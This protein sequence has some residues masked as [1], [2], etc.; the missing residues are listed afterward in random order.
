[1]N[2][3]FRVGHRSTF[4][5]Q[6]II[7]RR[8]DIGVK[9][10]GL[11]VIIC[12]VWIFGAASL[13]AP[14][15]GAEEP[16]L[17]YYYRGEPRALKV[18]PDRVALRMKVPGGE[19]DN[20]LAVASARVAY[21]ADNVVAG[22]LPGWAVLDA[23]ALM[24]EQSL[25]KQKTG[26]S[27]VEALIDSVLK[28]GDPN[29]D[30]VSPVFL[31]DRGGTIL[32]TDR[33]LI[34]FNPDTPKHKRE[35]LRA[36]VLEGIS[37]EKVK[38]PQPN[39]ERWIVTARSGLTVLT[40]ANAL[41]RTPGVA[42]AE[43][44]MIV[45]GYTQFVPNDPGF[46]ESWGLRNT[47]QS[48]GQSGFDLAA[49]TAWDITIGS[50]S[51]IVLVMDSGVQQNHPDINQVTGRDFT[52]DAASNPNGG[53]VGIY[54]NHGTAVA[55][56]ISERI[57][58]S[59]GTT[60]IAPGAKVA[61]ARIGTNYQPNGQFMASL[62]WFADALYWGQSIGARVSNN[63]NSWS[64]PSSAVESAYRS[65]R[66]AGMVH[67]ASA[68]NNGT[69]EIA[70]PSSIP[71]VNSVAAANR[72]GQ[73]AY[74]SQF[75][76]GLAFTAP[77][78]DIL[79]TDR[80]GSLGYNNS[81]DYISISGTSFAS[82][83]AAGVAALVISRNPTWEAVQVEDSLKSTS[84]DIGATGYDTDYGYGLLNASH[85]VKG[86]ASQPNLTPYQPQGWS[87][88][89]LVS[90]VTGTHTDNSR[91]T[92]NDTLYVDFAVKNIGSMSA[93]QAFDIRIYVDNT[94]KEV[95]SV[96]SPFSPGE[97][98]NFSDYSLGRLPAGTHTIH[99]HV[100]S[101]N[102][103]E[104]SDEEDNIYTKVIRVELDPVI[105]V[106]IQTGAPLVRLLNAKS[107]EM[108]FRRFAYPKSFR[109]GVRV[110]LGDA[111]GDG[112]PDLIT[113]PGPGR[114]PRVMVFNGR[115]G[116]RLPGHI[117]SFLA[118]ARSFRGGVNVASGDVNGDGYP[119]LITGTGPGRGPRIKV[120]SGRN[121]A[122]LPG[123]IGSFL[124]YSPNFRGGVNIASGDVNGDGYDDVI[125]G[126][127]RGGIPHVKVF[128]GR[129]GARLPGRIG[130]FFAYARNF[131]GGVNVAS[132]DVNNDGVDDVITGAGPGGIPHVRVFSGRTGAQLA[133]P[134]GSF[135]A[136]GSQFSGGVNVASGDVDGDGFGDI[137]TGPG[138]GAK[139]HVRVFSG[140]TG[141]QLSRPMGSFFA[142]S[143]KFRGG[144]RVASD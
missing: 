31:D 87:D 30:F 4:G 26:A 60:G 59:I 58:N 2:K 9:T 67:F 135:L 71:E 34:G 120:F 23:K 3:S 65:T 28:K 92:V 70:Y 114:G 29:V 107:G 136:Y 96:P 138:E 72:Y 104:E 25:S 79:T 132:G 52:T 90:N 16:P 95:L 39:D 125:T 101:S 17:F 123:R 106:G 20:Q 80:T 48:G 94:L 44:D 102:V 115:N 21:G 18:D 14:P 7:H 142:Y 113:G 47:G 140:R 19:R 85:A 76:N 143:P 86:V 75:G 111:N 6:S 89:I 11:R 51:V 139:P 108:I 33:I 49:T 38:F 46:I 41:A 32:L 91:L 40:R 63:S 105:A 133:P 103:I 77:G 124:A 55:G 61:S 118:Y 62:T 126:A 74:F 54:D 88:R 127:G 117:G 129:S 144:V 119:D 42:Y 35:E 5:P 15:L 116:A 83:Y 68:G 36:S 10:P 53:P 22:P 13:T 45:A 134:I 82:P 27:R 110:V 100:D 122:R 73:R 109:G 141:A 64:M 112:Y 93:T 121:G 128:S 84:T 131:R 12:I 130:N 81:G 99:I 43:P 1:M 97:S 24:A 56:C 50:P 98:Q 8:L 78:E 66:N 137:T 57:N 37:I 69:S